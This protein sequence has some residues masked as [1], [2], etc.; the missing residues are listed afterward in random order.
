[1]SGRG[2]ALTRSRCPACGTV[3]RVTSEQLR[4]KAGKVRCG[5]CQTVFNAFDHLQVET[6]AAPDDLQVPDLPPPVETV[7]PTSWSGDSGAVTVGEVAEAL[8]AEPAPLAVDVPE[9]PE[10]PVASP[11]EPLAEMPQDV[12]PFPVAPSA[13]DLSPVLA[14]PLAETPEESTQAAREA[15]LVAIR[16]LADSTTFNRW[17]AGALASDG[18]GSFDD[19]TPRSPVWPYVLVFVLLLLMLGGQLAYHF[20]TEVVLRLPAAAALYSALAIE[21]PLPQDAAL[22]SIETS[23]L[24]SDNGRGLF[25]LNATLKNRATHAQA[26]PSL[27]LTLT[28][29]NDK[30]VA[31]RVIGAADY[32][33]P[34]SPQAAFPA[35]GETSVRL[36]IEASGI[37]AAGY[38]LYIFYP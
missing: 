25:V 3:F 34:G 6:A 36:W 30:V 32:L 8:P 28:D 4:L 18:I 22:V 23:D 9:M 37:G 20:R 11:G 5:H 29:V 1:M 19:A 31:R 26:W 13:D 17:S 24:Q 7:A 35:N 14:A 16:E 12:A 33:S 21:V 15:G 38:R 10:M 27:E 2:P